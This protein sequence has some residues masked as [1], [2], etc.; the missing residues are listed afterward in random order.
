MSRHKLARKTLGFGK[1]G[2]ATVEPAE[3]KATLVERLRKIGGRWW[4]R[5]QPQKFKGARGMGA[6]R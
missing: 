2:R 1:R 4:A 3:R 6:R 5:K